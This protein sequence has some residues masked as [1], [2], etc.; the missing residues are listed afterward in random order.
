MTATAFNRVPMSQVAARP[1]AAALNW[2]WHGYLAPGQITLLT[3]RWKTGK[4]TLLT[5]LLR[6]LAEGG[7][8]LGQALR[9]V[10]ALVVSEESD[11]IWAERLRFMPVGAHAELL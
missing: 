1:G 3:S 8:F 11:A 7:T 6:A 9:P 2:L 10:K 4:T 5:G